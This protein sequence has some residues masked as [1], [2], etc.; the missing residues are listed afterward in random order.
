VSDVLKGLTPS[1]VWS[2]F[3]QIA[4]IPRPSKKEER[5]ASHVISLARKAGLDVRQDSLGNIL[6]CKPATPG[7]D[8]APMVALQSHLDMVC[9]KNSDV[10]H[11]FDHD[12]IQ[13]I[14]VDGHIKARGT[15]LGSDNGIGVAAAL[16]VMLDSKLVHGPLE[17]LFTIDEETGLTGA[18]GLKQGFVKSRILLNLDTE[19]EGAIYVGCAGGRDSLLSISIGREKA[20]HGYEPHSLMIRGLRGGHSGVDIHIGKGNALKVIGKTLSDMSQSGDILLAHIEGG[21]KRN[22]IPREAVAHLYVNSAAIGRLRDCVNRLQKMFS[23]EYSSVDSGVALEFVASSQGAAKQPLRRSDGVRVIGLLNTLP[24]G[25]LAMSPDMPGLVETSTNVATIETME[26]RVIIGTSQRSSVRENLD[27]A[28]NAVASLARLVSADVETTDGYPGWKP[29]LD[30]AALKVAKM[31]YKELFGV[32]PAI[33]AIHAGLECGIIGERFPGMDMI[34][35]GP[36][37]EGAHSP[38]ERVDIATVQK[39]W[40]FLAATLQTLSEKPFTDGVSHG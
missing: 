31:T 30:S 16:A 8:R 14:R 33:K 11:D 23:I 7:R 35:F 21:S 6:V 40:D 2:H 1:P 5:I 13:L 39:F 28:V 10:K 4:E 18:A 34:S 15:T 36:T 9:E 12:A 32:E 25:A 24:H 19:E 27:Q 20:P 3:G 37:I 38:D 29:N 17:F 22:A 26:S